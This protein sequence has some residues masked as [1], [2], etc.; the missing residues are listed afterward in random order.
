MSIDKPIIKI[1][2]VFIGSK[3]NL[4]CEQC[5]TRSDIFKDESNDPSLEEIFES[6]LL[7]QKHF[8]IDTYS[9]LGGEPLL[10]LEKTSK[11]IKFLRDSDPEGRIVLPTNGTLLAKHMDY[12][13]DLVNKYD[14][15]VAITDHFINFQDKKL[16]NKIKNSTLE[17]ASRLKYQKLDGKEFF[18][19]F[20]EFNNKDKNIFWKR[21][22]QYHPEFLDHHDNNI[23]YGN[24][25]TWI[26]M[27]LQEEFNSHYY[28]DENNKPKPFATE[29]CSGSYFTGCAS[30]F[31]SFLD[32]KKLYKC[33]ALGTL[34]NFL[35]KENA[36]EDPAWQK[37]Q[38]YQPLDLENCSVDDT[39]SF[40]N[41]Q[42]AESHVCDMC[43]NKD[44]YKI[45]KTETNVLPKKIIHIH[46]I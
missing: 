38:N 22:T 24:D 35:K 1:L 13:V 39:I 10:Y 14:I 19:N 29:D 4:S 2:N 15:C 6:V 46:E 42:F 31:C 5:D 21:F 40:S 3:C 45:I 28:R 34:E 44:E 25:K 12:V 30:L 41:N 20:I 18:A 23:A 11:I 8:K 27:H 36:T 9:A 7:V 16:S 33:A 17:L 37:Y 32:R 26:W 43:P